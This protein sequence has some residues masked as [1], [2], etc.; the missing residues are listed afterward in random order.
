MTHE[1]GHRGK[2][3]TSFR[4]AAQ[5]AV[6]RAESALGDD[7]KDEQMYELHLYAKGLKGNSLSEYIVV[8]TPR[9]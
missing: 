5:D 9:D 4:E 8:A 3:D 6:R 1:N 7:L 2:S